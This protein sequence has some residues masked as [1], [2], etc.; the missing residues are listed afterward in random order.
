MTDIA[1]P[2]SPPPKLQEV[3]EQ[4]PPT[5]REVFLP[6]LTG[7]TAA[8]YLSYWLKRWGT[9]VGETTIKEYRRQLREEGI[10]Q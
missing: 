4:F 10:I 8:S 6:H 2:G 3:W 5:V 1:L 7:G 9:P